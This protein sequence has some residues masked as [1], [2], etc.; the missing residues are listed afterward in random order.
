MKKFGNCDKMTNKFSDKGIYMND[1]LTYQILLIL[2]FTM[3]SAFFSASE[4]AFTTLNTVRIKS[5]AN[6]GNHR[7]AVTLMLAENYDNLLSTILIGNNIV[8]IA[9]AS[10][11]TIVFTNIYGSAG[12]TISTAAMTIIVLIFG[13]IA[14]KFLAK[15][16][17][18]TFAL[19]ATPI[20]RFFVFLFTPLNYLS[21]LWKKA[22]R[23][24]FKRKDEK[25][26]TQEELMTFVDEAQN[27]GGIDERNGELIRSAIEFNDLDANDILT[28]RVNIVAVEQKAPLEKI[29]ELFLNTNYSRLPV[30][31]ES[32]DNIIG[33]IHEKDFFRALH[34]GDISMA[35]II[36]KVS[37]V[38]TGMKISDLLRL[39]QQV[40]THMAVVVDEFGGTQGIVTMEDILEELVGD[41]WDEHDE[42]IDY[43][44]QIDDL[45]FEVNCSAT[46]DDMF[47]FFHIKEPEE[48]FDSV[49]VSGWIMEQLGKIPTAGDSFEFQNV[50]IV[51]TKTAARHATV[52]SVRL[53]RPARSSEE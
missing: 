51:V 25:K 21:S 5:M 11:A 30:Y 52:A 40:K 26:V 7:A 45:T 19:T 42:V 2:T 6:T 3:M 36:K 14:P 39:L 13:E 4:T 33:M 41:I 29:T 10:I 47:E 12:V 32:I 22:L 44:K 24:I 53:N 37:Y 17:P 28:P 1:Q 27:D 9:G 31:E 15:E 43:F 20:L 18:E 23:H 8:N 34:R 38:G 16:S 46:L 48:E 35:S 49:T 50:N